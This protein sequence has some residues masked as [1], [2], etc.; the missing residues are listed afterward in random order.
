MGLQSKMYTIG[1][2]RSNEKPTFVIGCRLFFRKLKNATNILLPKTAIFFSNATTM[3]ME[4][5]SKTYAAR[6]IQISGHFE[7]SN[8]KELTKL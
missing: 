5:Y 1:H 2:Y 8:L 6:L 4:K 7:L 3:Y